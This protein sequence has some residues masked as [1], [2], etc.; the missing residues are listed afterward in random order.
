MEVPSPTPLLLLLLYH[1]PCPLA[2]DWGGRV[3]GLVLH[4]FLFCP[5]TVTG[6][7]GQILFFSEKSINFEK[8][9]LLNKRTYR[10]KIGPIMKIWL[11]SLKWDQSGVS[12]SIP[13][14]DMS[15]R[16]YVILQMERKTTT[17]LFLTKVLP[18]GFLFEI[19][20][21]A[22]LTLFLNNP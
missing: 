6:C 14:E 19:S 13:L 16:S 7:K 17:S 12:R 1:C 18:C 21:S 3:S 5:P 2:R 22:C 15:F 10:R 4:Q 11:K 9:L 8:V 20:T